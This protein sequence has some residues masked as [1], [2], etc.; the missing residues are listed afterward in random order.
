M[1]L[2]RPRLLVASLAAAVA[3][4]LV[5]GWALASTWRD[6]GVPDD[7]VLAA[8]GEYELPASGDGNPDVVGDQLP[9]VELVDAS[10]APVSLRDYAGEPLVVNLWYASCPPC[11]REL[12]DFAAVDAETDGVRFVGV[13]PLDAPV[14]MTEFAAERGVRYDLL[15]DPD[16]AFVDALGVV[17]FPVTLFVDAGGRVVLQAGAMDADELRF[18]LG[19]VF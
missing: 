18:H 16:A 8:P 3:V 19:H 17:N 10:G 1:A 9:D 5:G 2:R 6:D 12:S 11:A 15:R 4:S 7:I 14:T 13:N